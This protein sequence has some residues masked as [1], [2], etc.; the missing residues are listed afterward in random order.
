MTAALGTDA[1]LGCRL[2]MSRIAALQSF[3]RDCAT[4]AG[5][6]QPLSAS[7]R[8]TRV[9]GLVMEAVGL[10]LAVGSSCSVALPSG[11]P[12]DAEV[13]GFAEDRLF[14]MPTNDVDGVVP[15][16]RVLPVEKAPE[17]A[18]PARPPR[19]RRRAS[20]QARHVPVGPGLLGRVLDGAGRPLDGLGT[21][22]SIAPYRS[23]TVL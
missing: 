4:A 14:L 22:E 7:G 12:I 6:T 17:P 15:G 21:L 2:G 10:R 1:R 19:P 13:V 23:T 3:V 5:A 20:D 18:S 8:L 11:S 9:T 16:A